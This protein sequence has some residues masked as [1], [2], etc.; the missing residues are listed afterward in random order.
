[1]ELGWIERC[2]RHLHHQLRTLDPDHRVRQLHRDPCPAGARYVGCQIS[3]VLHGPALGNKMFTLIISGPFFYNLNYSSFCTVDNHRTI[4]S[5]SSQFLA[6]FNKCVI[7]P[8]FGVNLILIC[9]KRDNT[10]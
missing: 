1:M 7:F 10:N 2:Q 3:G 8:H 4:I 6:F 9:T 5:S